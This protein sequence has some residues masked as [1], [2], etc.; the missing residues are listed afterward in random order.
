MGS[1]VSPSLASIFVLTKE[2][3]YLDSCDKKPLTYNRFQD[4]IFG[5]WTHGMSSLNLFLDGLNSMHKD[6][7]FTYTSSKTNM[8]FLDISISLDPITGGII[9]DV[10]RK[11][12]DRQSYLNFYSNHPQH[13]K[14]AIPKGVSN[15][16]A[17]ICSTKQLYEKN[18]TIL[19]EKLLQQQYPT[20]L[21]ENSVVTFDCASGSDDPETHINVGD[22]NAVKTPL[23]ISRL[24]TTFSSKL[25]NIGHIL[26]KHFNILTVS[27]FNAFVAPP[28]VTYK[29]AKNLK[30]ILV[31][32]DFK[33]SEIPSLTHQDTVI[34]DIFPCSSPNKCIMCQSRIK[35]KFINSINKGF[36]FEIKNKIGCN[37]PNLVYL[38]ECQICGIQYIGQAKNFRKRW[39]NHHNKSAFIGNNPIIVHEQQTGHNGDN[40]SF[41]LLLKCD[42]ANQLNNEERTLIRKFEVKTLGLNKNVGIR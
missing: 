6:L 23:D 29:K 33:M 34:S 13:V 12:T 1:R 32:S 38:L 39:H 20:S 8:N 27:K 11:P 19:K 25:P 7:K 15:R 17:K 31:H 41:A 10:F 21:I 3:K 28:E 22:N 36:L 42:N 24:I 26:A 16:I 40:F 5:I 37:D 14:N 18:I 2:E 9:T 4:D 35:T 30:S